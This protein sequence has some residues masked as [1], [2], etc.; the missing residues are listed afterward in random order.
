MKVYVEQ[1]R[2]WEVALLPDEQKVEAI[3]A[4]KFAGTGSTGASAIA[5]R[6]CVW[7]TGRSVWWRLCDLRKREG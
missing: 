4:A 6:S 2:N 7:Q 1:K 3:L 5:R